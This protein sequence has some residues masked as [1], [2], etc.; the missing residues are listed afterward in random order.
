M[1][2]EDYNAVCEILDAFVAPAASAGIGT[3]A[4]KGGAPAGPQSGSSEGA[5]S[6]APP[7]LSASEGGVTS[8]GGPAGPPS[9]SSE[10]ASSAAT[11]PVHH[12][13]PAQAHAPLPLL[14]AP[15]GLP[16]GSSATVAATGEKAPLDAAIRARPACQFLPSAQAGGGAA[17]SEPY[18]D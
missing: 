14:M 16:S 12:Q 9:G 10:G 7:A 11:P 2:H 8:G 18:R 1:L 5:S 13:A 6:S 17:G 15:A 3:G 4:D